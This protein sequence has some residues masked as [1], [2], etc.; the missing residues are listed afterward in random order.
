MIILMRLGRVPSPRR[1]FAL[2]P[3]FLSP[4][5]R[6]LH[7]SPSHDQKNHQND[8]SEI[9]NNGDKEIGRSR[10]PKGYWNDAANVRAALDELVTEQGLLDLYQLS[11][12]SF[13][14]H[15]R[16]IIIIYI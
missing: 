13:T 9:V 14:V 1:P 15:H 4:P 11:Q 5:P 12:K 6:L 16:F 10:V 7:L 3:P 2:I 8:N